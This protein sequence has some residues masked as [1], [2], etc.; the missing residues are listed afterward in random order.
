LQITSDNAADAL[1]NINNAVAQRTKEY[2]ISRKQ[3]FQY[4]CNWFRLTQKH[5]ALADAQII[6][7]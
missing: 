3:L 5:K 7:I 2:H 1:R 4:A 6:W